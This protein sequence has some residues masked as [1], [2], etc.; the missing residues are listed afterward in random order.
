VFAFLMTVWS[1]YPSTGATLI[2]TEV[3]RAA[4][5]FSDA[6]SGDDWCL[7]VSLAFGGRLGWSE[8]PGRVYRLH[9]GSIWTRYM[10]ADNQVR[11]A[12]IVRQRV[13]E[14]PSVGRG[15]KL[16]LP[17]IALAQWG[18]IGAHLI[19]AAARRYRRPIRR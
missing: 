16:A 3:A 6:D 19:V 18:A 10:A 14:D 17:V 2:R 4:G 11:H 1:I 13:R 9:E 15:P 5:G 12:R 7:A 8:R